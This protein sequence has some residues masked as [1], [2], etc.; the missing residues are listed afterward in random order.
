MPGWLTGFVRIE[1]N[2]LGWAGVFLAKKKKEMRSRK[3]FVIILL[4]LSMK[5]ANQIFSLALVGRY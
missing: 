1:P 2:S 5:Y 4:N 3:L